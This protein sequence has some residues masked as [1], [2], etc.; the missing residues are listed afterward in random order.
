MARKNT[1]ESVSVTT[2]K[3][4][5]AGGAATPE[6]AAI[7]VSRLDARRNAAPT[8][9]QEKTAGGPQKGARVVVEKDHRAMR[10]GI[11]TDV[12]LGVLV[13]G[14]LSWVGISTHLAAVETRGLSVKLDLFS[15]AQAQELEELTT[16]FESLEL[17]IRAVEN[18]EAA[19]RNDQLGEF[20]GYRNQAP[21]E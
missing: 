3:S 20:G 11:N 6:P 18:L 5:A 12:V 10:V 13:A 17:R 2:D 9:D 16:R 7:A 21:P 15:T 8:D 4:T 19:R 1:L 14:L